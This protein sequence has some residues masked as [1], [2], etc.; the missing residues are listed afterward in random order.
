MRNSLHKTQNA[1]LKTFAGDEPGE[2]TGQSGLASVKKIQQVFRQRPAML[3]WIVLY[4]GKR[5][6]I[7]SEKPKDS[8]FPALDHVTTPMSSGMRSPASKSAAMPPD[9]K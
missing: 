6:E 7:G 1:A 3:N 9:A 2:Q 8:S 4:A 5:E